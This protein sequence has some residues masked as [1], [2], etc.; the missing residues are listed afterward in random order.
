MEKNQLLYN[1]YKKEEINKINNR[2]KE[3]MT[4]EEIIMLADKEFISMEEIQDILG[5]DADEN[6]KE[7]LTKI[8]EETDVIIEDIEENKELK[9][10]EV[11]ILKEDILEDYPNQPFNC[12]NETKMI[13]MMESIRINGIIHPLIVRPIGEGKYQILSGHNRRN[14]AKKIGIKEV[15]CIIKHLNN[16]QAQ[17]YVIDTNLC[18]RD[19]LLPMERAKAYKIK[20]DN[21]K[22]QNI[23]QRIFQ[24]VK[25]DVINATGKIKEE[26]N[27][28]SATI[29]RYLRLNC[30]IPK[31]QELIDNGKL[32]VKTGEQ[33]SFLSKQE[34]D[35]LLKVIIEDNKKIS[36]TMACKIRKESE[37]NRLTDKNKIKN[38]LVKEKIQDEI[39]ICF[40]IEE[41]QK[42]FNGIKEKRELKK[43]ILELTNRK[44]L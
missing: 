33:L 34:Q 4:N 23:F 22:R 44:T 18:T 2:K 6:N 11:V 25:N 3:G 36:Q 29:Q 10:S 43:Y 9:N 15:P 17:L 39:I 8:V 19:N 35:L 5:I 14:C 26:E 16:E 12:Y 40:T 7:E 31:L 41:I 20:Y 24:E 28:S 42:Y 21:Y 30:L 38:L 32:G 1:Y 27:I 13:E 37:K